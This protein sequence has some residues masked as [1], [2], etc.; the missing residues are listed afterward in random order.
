ML[1]APW[2]LLSLVW[3]HTNLDKRCARRAPARGV[4]VLGSAR[5]RRKVSLADVSLRQVRLE[6]AKGQRSRH[7]L[8]EEVERHLESSGDQPLEGA[9]EIILE[10]MH[11]TPEDPHL[12]R[13]LALLHER[14][15]DPAGARRMLAMAKG[16]E[17]G[18]EQPQPS[19]GGRLLHARVL[20]EAGRVSEAEEVAREAI[21]A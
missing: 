7:G 1:R 19:L 4:D 12:M 8:L 6:V 15:G 5:Y 2:R 9:L 21:A 18:A 3:G 13:L 10:E 14:N 11:N 17:S 16:A 20:L